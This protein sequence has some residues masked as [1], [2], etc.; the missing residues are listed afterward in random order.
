MK[1]T[2]NKE[3]FTKALLNTTK[4]IQPKSIN[5]ALVN[6]KMV[7]D[8]N[9][10][11]LTG[12]NGGDIS[13]SQ[14]I[15]LYSGDQEIIR[16]V[17]PGG[18][19][20]NAQILTNIAR[21]IDGAELTFELMD[22][23]L[24]K[25][26][27]EKSVFKLNSI[28]VEEYP[29]IDF[30]KSGTRVEIPTKDFIDSVNEVSFAALTKESRPILTAVNFCG[31]NG[32]LTMTATDGARLAEKK[33]SVVLDQVFSI[34][35]PSK[36]LME[37]VKSITN[38]QKIVLYISEK[39]VI[40]ELKDTLISSRLVAGEYPNTKNIIPKQFNYFLEVNANEFL[41][42]MNRTSLLSVERENVVKVTMNSQRVEISS[43]SQQVGSAVE[44]LNVFK[45]TGERLEIS[46]NSELVSA[47]IK[48]LKSEDV[49]ISFIGE[50]K[51]FT[52][53][54]KNDS[55]IIQLITPV[56]TY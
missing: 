10:L 1:F 47:A 35:I 55:N 33:L 26:A 29:E 40:F 50:M 42:A 15:P 4:I 38:E 22:D 45:F 19:L 36:S 5:A 13:I 8:A 41:T 51:P 53:T 28:R 20:V 43:K 7:L 21:S 49:L 27:N 37:C 17:R 56:R 30:S 34:N 3:I 6:I 32:C 18:V 12:S 25:I 52:V 24:A 11:N 16:D 44:S 54:N 46:F 9:G 2:I 23:S 39:K 48:A 31:S 14:T